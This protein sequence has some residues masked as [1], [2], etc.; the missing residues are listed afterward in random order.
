MCDSRLRPSGRSDLIGVKRSPN[1][2]PFRS[3][4][5]AESVGRQSVGIHWLVSRRSCRCELFQRNSLH[6]FLKN[7]VLFLFFFVYLRPPPFP[8]RPSPQ[9]RTSSRVGNE[10]LLLLWSFQRSPEQIYLH[11]TPEIVLFVYIKIYRL[12]RWRLFRIAWGNTETI[13]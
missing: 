7:L 5:M 9:V 1:Q 2:P 3:P 8:S 6:G 12:L 4:P 13:T 10:R 11:F